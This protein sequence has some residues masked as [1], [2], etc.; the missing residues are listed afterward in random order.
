MFVFSAVLF[1]HAAL[2]LMLSFF[3]FG[4]FKNILKWLGVDRACKR[5]I[6]SVVVGAYSELLIGALVNTENYSLFDSN[7]GK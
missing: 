1:A 3:K 4:P 7:W 2:T 6:F 5:I